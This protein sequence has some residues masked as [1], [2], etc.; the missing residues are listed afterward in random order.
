MRLELISI[1]SFVYC[2]GNENYVIE[3]PHISTES[4]VYCIDPVVDNLHGLPFIAIKCRGADKRCANGSLMGCPAHLINVIAEIIISPGIRNVIY[5]VNY[6]WSALIGGGKVFQYN[7]IKP[8]F[9]IFCFQL[10]RIQSI[11]P[12]SK[13]ASAVVLKYILPSYSNRKIIKMIIK[14]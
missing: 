7:P 9:F 11:R 4:Q 1:C 13:L 6:N 8:F 12:V 14:G 3:K 10:E 2:I 5:C